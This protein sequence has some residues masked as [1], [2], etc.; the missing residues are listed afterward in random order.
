MKLQEIQKVID[1][2]LSGR[3]I[4]AYFDLCA[5]GNFELSHLEFIA[6]A[7]KYLSK[8]E[9]TKHLTLKWLEDMAYST[10]ENIPGVCL[11]FPNDYYPAKDDS[12][13]MCPSR[14]LG[15]AKETEDYIIYP[16][17]HLEEWPYI[18]F[19]E[20]R[21]YEDVPKGEIV[22][23]KKDDTYLIFY[24]APLFDLLKS[25]IEIFERNGLNYELHENEQF[26]RLKYGG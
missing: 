6:I 1:E 17:T 12:L 15:F 23:R 5:R 19:K 2:H 24:D 4:G 14:S 21:K 8:K 10:G 3:P 20:P 26:E 18:Y 22:Y 11:M 13:V 9:E 25:T 7:C 16:H